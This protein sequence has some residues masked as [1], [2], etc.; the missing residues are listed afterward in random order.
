MYCLFFSASIGRKN[1]S[2]KRRLSPLPKV[3]KGPPKRAYDCT[4][5]ETT[6]ISQAQTKAYFEKMKAQREKQKKLFP[7]TPAEVAKSWVMVD[8]LNNPPVYDLD[9]DRQIKKSDD[10]RRERV[11]KSRSSGSGKSVAQ[12]GLQ[13]NQSCPPLKVFSDAEVGT[14]RTAAEWAIDPEFVELYGKDAAAQGMTIPEF[15]LQLQTFPEDE[16][17]P[18][19]RSGHPLVNPNEVKDLPTKMRRVHSWYMQESAKDENWIYLRIANRHYGHG[20][21]TVMIEFEELFQLFQMNDLDKSILS[22]YCL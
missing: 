20:A 10:A 15:L 2:P 3:P 7:S 21:G 16:I 13:K 9:Y 8:N 11:K 4:P 14:S 19:F 18:K 12:L 6:T 22:A 17:R 5:E 1:G